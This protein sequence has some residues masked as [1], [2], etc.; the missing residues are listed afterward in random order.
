VPIFEECKYIVVYR[1]GRDALMSWANHRGAMRPEV[2][3]FVNAT[4]AEEGLG[5]PT[6]RSGS[7]PARSPPAAAPTRCSSRRQEPVCSTDDPP[8]EILANA[9]HPTSP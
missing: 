3:D 5:R 1:D 8:G 7:S 9:G 6:L 4:G 2:I